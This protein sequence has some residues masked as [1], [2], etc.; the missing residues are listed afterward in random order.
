MGG[1][2]RSSRPTSRL[3]AYTSMPNTRT[4]PLVLVATSDTELGEELA[5]RVQLAGFVACRARSA[6]GCLRVATSIAPDIVLLDTRL[7]GRLEHMLRAHPATA[8]SRL[9][10]VSDSRTGLVQRLRAAA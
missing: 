1:K 7:A 9:V 3:V 8:R 6:E 5:Q 2:V 4:C 10:V